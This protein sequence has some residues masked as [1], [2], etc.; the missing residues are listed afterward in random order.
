MKP[1][2][3]KLKPKPRVGPVTRRRIKAYLATTANLMRSV[4]EQKKGARHG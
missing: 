2:Q 1:S 3:I 4:Q